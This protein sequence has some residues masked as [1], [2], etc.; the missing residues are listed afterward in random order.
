[1]AGVDLF[2]PQSED[3]VRASLR[4][5]KRLA[6]KRM[7]R[8]FDLAIDYLEN[9]QI[10]D[11]R[12]ELATRYRR[13][14]DG[15]SGQRIE[16]LCLP[17]TERY[18]A[19]AASAYNKPVK[20]ELVDSVSGVKNEEATKELND[21]LEECSYDETMHRMEQV[22]VLLGSCGVWFQAKRGA[23]RPVIV[24][25]HLIYP[26]Q[27]DSAEA[28]DAADQADYLGHVIAVVRSESGKSHAQTWALI[29][30]AEH[31]YF[32]ARDP[33]APDKILDTYPNPFRWPQMVDTE[34]SK[35]KLVDNA[36]LQLMTIWHRRKPI[37]EILPDCDPEIVYL[38]RELNVQWSVLMD[39]MRTQGWAQMYM[40]LM[41]P[42]TPPT[43]IAYGS[44]FVLPLSPGESVGAVNA[45]N[46][47]AGMVEVLKASLRTFAMCKRMSPQDFAIDGA[48]PASGFAKLID[49]LPKIEAR[50]ERVRRLVQAEQQVAWPRIGAIL[51]YLGKLSVDPTKLKM[52]V[53][54]AG[55]EFP[56]TADET[57]QKQEHEFKHGLS[58]PAEV[59]AK[60]LGITVEEAQV[61]IDERRAKM[62]QQ[63]AEAGAVA[64]MAQKPS[65]FGDVIR[66]RKAAIG[67]PGE[68][69]EENPEARPTAKPTAK[70]KGKPAK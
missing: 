60:R 2:R 11:V 40:Q 24:Y 53:E 28:F 6:R 39:T 8:E 43:S 62:P 42:E 17:L 66:Q 22:S 45:G 18:I 5:A 19:E 65:R 3:A 35:G 26:V 63:P 50:N 31:I 64:G 21:A 32:E 27:Q 20:R 30:P 56:E 52:R 47:Y 46:D 68:A 69:A 16:P 58:S 7:V 13:T 37:D 51:R 44:R 29:T 4:E 67:K 59:L 25:P 55:I 33:Y 14:Q 9:R 41:N 10:E 15:G 57:A 48:A 49:S 38:N 61:K 36:P 34:D 54:F 23:L 1:M 12:G 70:A